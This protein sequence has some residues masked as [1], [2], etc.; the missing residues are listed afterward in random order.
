M[1]L[2]GKRLPFDVTPASYFEIN[3]IGS[4]GGES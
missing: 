2:G 3:V 1:K 4:Y